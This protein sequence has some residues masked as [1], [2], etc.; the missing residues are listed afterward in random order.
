MFLSSNSN[1]VLINNDSGEVMYCFFKINKQDVEYRTIYSPS[2][3]EVTK[4]PGWPK[5]AIDI[6]K[7]TFYCKSVRENKFSQV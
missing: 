4:E 1:P 2:S 5:T 3:T 7:E 6:I